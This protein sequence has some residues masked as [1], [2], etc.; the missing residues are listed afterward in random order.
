MKKFLLI[1]TIT[2]LNLCLFSQQKLSICSDECK[3]GFINSF[4]RIPA[5]SIYRDRNALYKVA[6]LN[7]TADYVGTWPNE[8][9]GAFNYALDIWRHLI[10]SSIPIKIK[11]EWKSLDADVLGSTYATSYKKNFANAPF[12][13]VNYPVSLAE[14]LSGTHLNGS[15]EEISIEINSNASWYYGLDGNTPAEKHDLASVVIHEIAH[16]LGFSHSMDVE[17]SIGSWGQ[18]YPNDNE[19]GFPNSYDKFCIYGQYSTS[20]YRLINTNQYPNP[21]WELANVLQSDNLYFDGPDTKQMYSNNLPKLYSPNPFEEGSTL[22]HFDENSFPSGDPNSLMTPSLSKAESIHSPGVLGLS[23]LQDLGW[24]V[25]RLITITSPKPGIAYIP[26]QTKEIIWT[27]NIGGEISID[28]LK[29]DLSGY[30]EF[31]STIATQASLPGVSNSVNW[32]IPNAEGTFKIR[33]LNDPFGDGLGLSAPFIISPQAQV[34]T[35]VI[36]PPGGDYLAAQTITISCA[37]PGATIYYSD[38]GTEPSSSNGTQYTVPFIIN[39]DKI[40]K[41]IAIKTGYPDSEIKSEIYTFAAALSTVSFHHVSGEYPAPLRIEAGW[42]VDMEGYVARTSN[43]SAPVDPKTE[44]WNV[45]FS[46][47]W[48]LNFETPNY[49]VKINA[50]TKKNGNWGPL[51]N[52]QYIIKPSLRIA[53][54]DDEI[55]QGS[56]SFGYWYKWENEQWNPHF[57]ETI[58]RPTQTEDWHIRALQDFKDPTNNIF[59]KYNV[60]RKNGSENFFVNHANISI[61]SSTSS[62]LAHFKQTYDVTLAN[63]LE[64]TISINQGEVIFKNPW[65]VDDYSDSKGSRNR[66][67]GTSEIPLFPYQINFSTSPNITN[68]SNHKGVFLDQGWPNWTPPYYSVQA[69]S[70]QTFTLS[71]TGREHTFYFQNW[72]ANTIGGN[73]GAIFQ[74]A[75]APSTGVVFKSDGA[76]VSANMKGTQLSSESNAFKPNGQNKIVRI[77]NGRMYQVYESMGNIWLEEKINDQSEWTLL[78][79]LNG[80][81]AKN[82]SLTYLAPSTEAQA[83]TLIVVYAEEYGTC[84]VRVHCIDMG[85]MI[86]AS[87]DAVYLLSDF[88]A[89]V[90]PVVAGYGTNKF[91][92]VV[93]EPD[94]ESSG[95]WYNWGQVSWSG[96]QLTITMEENLYGL[97]TVENT[98]QSSINPTIASEGEILQIAWEENSEIKYEKMEMIEGDFKFS[99]YSTISELSG[100]TENRN[101]SIMAA[102]DGARVVWTGRREREEE[103]EEGKI[104]GKN[105]I[106]KEQADSEIEYSVVFKDPSYWRYWHFAYDNSRPIQSPVIRACNS[107]YTFAWS[108]M[109]GAT[110]LSYFADNG[111]S[112]I[113]AIKK[114]GSAI[115]GKYVQLSNGTSQSEQYSSVFRQETHPYFFTMSDNINSLK[116]LSKEASQGISSG[117]EGILRKGGAQFYYGLGDIRNEGSVV[118]LTEL[119]DSAALNTVSDMNGYLESKTFDIAESGIISYSVSYG[120]ADSAG[121]VNCFSGREYIRFKLLLTDAETNE[122]IAAL[123]EVEYNAAN[124]SNYSR[125]MWQI[126]ASEYAGRRVKLILKAEE[127]IGADFTIAEKLCVENT[128]AK[129]HKNEIKINEGGKA[130]Q[131]NLFQNYPNPFNPLTQIRYQLPKDGLVTLKVFDILGEEVTTLV[132][133]TKPVGSYSVNFDATQLPSG[134]YLYELNAGDFRSVKKMTVVK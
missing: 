56:N 25:N 84:Q 110:G 62:V 132:N 70:P 57:D 50:R 91:M 116:A 47:P 37:T 72:S 5:P 15:E 21:S 130:L 66:G 133:E 94:N 26:G 129:M 19:K 73:P 74:N 126:D 7:I 71:Q 82:P 14:A 92:I 117:R 101:P 46:N 48:V 59:R 58:K 63:K 111:L 90:T 51:V 24:E 100:F 22:A 40:I 121:A 52:R 87:A 79:K 98:T 99:A 67:T 106:N 128:L 80:A 31:Y 9:K 75:N 123:D 124:V 68:N 29:R 18:K 35:P 4:T 3:A 114:N 17:N 118:E 120:V 113:K 8:A 20:I 43:G 55:T 115:N 53:Q 107:G 125:S 104:D 69:I 131:Y 27:D 88:S 122:I 97:P 32:T 28:L 76:V 95:M 78:G 10:K 134:I 96:V 30:Y 89:E 65:I 85:T 83:G 36:L 45:P 44:G 93:N 127:N 11:A 64:N 105:K 13:D 12:A 112:A 61:G 60:W 77:S 108:E 23:V 102:G 33:M 41:A 81:T 16:G 54:I 1:L 34:V 38:D 39:S 86:S 2:M 49:T 6:T 109:S 42:P 119:P 103:V